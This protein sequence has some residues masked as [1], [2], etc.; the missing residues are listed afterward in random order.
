MTEDNSNS[1]TDLATALVVLREAQTNLTTLENEIL[2]ESDAL[3]LLQDQRDGSENGRLDSAGE[4]RI[5]GLQRKIELLTS[6]KERAEIHLNEARVIIAHLQT[7]MT[8]QRTNTTDSGQV[9]HLEEK[10][11]KVSYPAN[12][13][14]Y[15]QEGQKESMTDPRLFLDQFENKLIGGYIDEKHWIRALL[16]HVGYRPLCQFIKEE[17]LDQPTPVGWEVARTKFLQR[18]LN[19]E[20]KDQYQ[21]EFKFIKLGTTEDIGDFVDRFETLATYCGRDLN[22]YDVVDKFVDAMYPKLKS[23]LTI[24][25][26]EDSDWQTNWKMTTAYAKKMCTVLAREASNEKKRPTTEED[27]AAK[28]T[29]GNNKD[30]DNKIKRTNPWGDKCKKEGRC[31]NCAEL[32]HWWKVCPKAKI[33]RCFGCGT[34]GEIRSKCRKCN[35][36]GNGKS[37]GDKNW[38]ARVEQEVKRRLNLIDKINGGHE[39]LETDNSSKSSDEYS[40][41]F[42]LLSIL[43]PPPKE[44]LIVVQ[45]KYEDHTIRVLLDCGATGSFIR[46]A[47]AKKLA[48]TSTK[49]SGQIQLCGEGEGTLVARIAET[50]GVQLSYGKRS[51]SIDLEWYDLPKN[52]NYDVVLGLPDWPKLG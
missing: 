41:P 6:Q 11:K 28:N 26:C 10:K 20:L 42:L 38:E 37:T 48:L 50:K 4:R 43:G 44:E 33:Q 22:D 39:D 31:S 19:N 8:H 49:S 52:G 13:P 36:N 7:T 12:M 30:D 27:N 34:E 18:C 1:N 21:K 45:F 40:Q 23:Q 2:N 14:T 17:L 9:T 51:G 5:R 32:G 35:K 24:K 29:T 15:R 25:L 47:L 46:P 16:G 3:D